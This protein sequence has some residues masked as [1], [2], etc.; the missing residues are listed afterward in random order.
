MVWSSNK[1]GLL[2][3]QQLVETSAK[4]FVKP[5]KIALIYE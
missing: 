5:M 3:P 1:K 4:G 2:W